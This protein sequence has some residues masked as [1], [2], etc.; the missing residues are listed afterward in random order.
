M[1]THRDYSWIVPLIYLIII[2]FAIF[3]FEY[4]LTGG[5]KNR[6]MP[7]GGVIYYYVPPTLYVPP[8]QIYMVPTQEE[9]KQ[10][11]PAQAPVKKTHPPPPPLE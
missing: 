8:R 7:P 4:I 6:R 11:K 3:V 9:H 1:Y 10:F 5:Q 2:V